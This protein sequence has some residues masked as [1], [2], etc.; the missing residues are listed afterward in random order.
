MHELIYLTPF[1][2]YFDLKQSNRSELTEFSPRHNNKEKT[3]KLSHL[4]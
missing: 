4:F 2:F 3:S 1:F